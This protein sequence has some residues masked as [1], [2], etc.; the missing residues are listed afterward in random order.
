MSSTGN[1]GDA[2]V[3]LF[4]VETFSKDSPDYEKNVFKVLD[5]VLEILDQFSSSSMESNQES[6]SQQCNAATITAMKI[7]AHTLR[8]SNWNGNIEKLPSKPSA[9]SPEE[10]YSGWIGE[11]HLLKG[12][13]ITSEELRQLIDDEQHTVVLVA[14]LKT[15]SGSK[16]VGCWKISTY[17]KNLQMTEEEKQDVAVEF[18]LNAVDPDYQSRGIGTLLYNGAVRIAKEYFNAQRVYSC[19]IRSKRNQIEWCL[20]QGFIDTGRLIP[21]PSKVQL[22]AKVDLDELKFSVLTKRL[23]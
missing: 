7:R 18:G 1:V 17:D 22:Q 3:K 4:S 6:S 13:R 11:Q 19:I 15:P 20:R 12:A 16:I 8:L 9:S 21:L 14:K 23:Q 5:E 10:S 2:A